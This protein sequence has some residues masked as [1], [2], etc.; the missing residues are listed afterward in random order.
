M[1]EKIDLN[2]LE[3][4]AYRE[5]QQDGLADAL[6]G[7]VLLAYAAFVGFRGPLTAVCVL[8][9]LVGGPRLLGVVRGRVIHPRI[10]Q[11][12][13]HQEKARDALTGVFTFIVLVIAVLAVAFALSGNL[14]DREVWWRWFP[15]FVGCILFGA[16]AYAAG[17][18]GSPRYQA[19]AV[20]SVAG[21]IAFSLPGFPSPE[22]RLIAY[23]V[24]MSLILILSSAAI[25]LRFLRRHPL[26][27]VGVP[28]DDPGS[29]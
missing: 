27:T 11:A 3:R 23:L 13:L 5:S 17:K 9:A 19:Y 7:I 18:S 6:L 16:L 20:L 8:V 21:G 4:R 12:R 29:Q 22:S 26:P 1:S 14:A 15:T 2:E 28:D 25:F 24:T 10:G